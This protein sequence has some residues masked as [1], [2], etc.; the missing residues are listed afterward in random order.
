MVQGLRP[1]AP[2]AGGS[3]SIPDQETRAHVP[4]TF[5]ATTKDLAC[6]NEDQRSRLPHL[7]LAR[8]N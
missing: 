3:G 1:H 7:R 4:K 5:Q 2:S 8:P 6:F